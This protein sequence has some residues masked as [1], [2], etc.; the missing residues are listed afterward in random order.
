M[1][2]IKV[3]VKSNNIRAIDK[4]FFLSKK[5]KN[6][7]AELNAKSDNSVS[8]NTEYG[9]LI[10]LVKNVVK[11]TSKINYKLSKKPYNKFKEVIK[12]KIK[13]KKMIKDAQKRARQARIAAEESAKKTYLTIKLI[14]KLLPKMLRLLWKLIPI[15]IGIIACT[16][17]VS[18]ISMISYMFGSSRGIFIANED[19]NSI[20]IKAIV[21]N[22]N[23]E[24]ANNINDIKNNNNYDDYKIISNKADWREVLSIYSVKTSDNNKNEVITIDENRINEIKSIFWTMNSINYEIVEENLS[25]EYDLE[26]QEIKKI[27]YI[28]INSKSKEEMMS[29][30]NFSESQK[31]D[32]EDLLNDFYNDLWM[33]TIY[34]LP[35]R[36]SNSIVSI[37]LSQVGNVG[38]DP[39]WSW[40][41]FE[42]RV[43][44]CAIFVSW[45]MNQAGVDESVL[46]KFS[47]VSTG[48]NWLKAK[49]AWHE[50]D[51]IPTSSDIIFFDWENDGI[52]N[53]VGIV[54]YSDDNYVYT[55]EGNSN[56][57]CKRNS[58]NLNSSV[59][60]GYGSLYQ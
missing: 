60:Y 11:T 21:N 42:S 36:N 39:Y 59:I 12:E 49:G 6:T 52:P 50:S 2:D 51:Y 35:I 16:V 26:N 27:L 25:E 18:I 34:G 22:L 15:I 43:E 45:V 14:K 40:Y 8:T 58:Y 4:S 48:V 33:A 32:V 24:M 56:D 37:A 20:T 13:T 28:Y 44:W 17:I 47:V 1:K 7:I 19:M 55:I 57:E 10:N 31:K 29:L 38:G 23:N 5:A 3:R 9:E 46:P 53:H 41:G 30:Y 54:E